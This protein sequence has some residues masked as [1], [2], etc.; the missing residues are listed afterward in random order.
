MKNPLTKMSIAAILLV[1]LIILFSGT[2]QSSIAWGKLLDRLAQMDYTYHHQWIITQEQGEPAVIESVISKSQ[3]YGIRQD[4]LWAGEAFSTV[5]IPRDSNSMIQLLHSNRQV[6]TTVMNPEQMDEIQLK[7]DPSLWIK[8]AMEFQ[9]RL[10]DPQ[11]LDGITVEGIEVTDSNYMAVL[12]EESS[13]HIWVNVETQLP[14][15]IEINGTS[16]QGKLSID[17]IASQFDWEAQLNA[18]V[19]EPNIPADYQH[20]TPMNATDSRQAGIQSLRDYATLTRG[21]YP[22]QLSIMSFM[23]EAVMAIALE[24]FT[25]PNAV[26]PTNAKMPL[27]SKDV[28][29]LAGF[30]HMGVFYGE[31]MADCNDVVY[32]GDHVMAQHSDMI[33][34]R[35]RDKQDSYQVIFGNLEAAQVTFDELAV[36]EQDPE[37]LA[38]LERPRPVMPLVTQGPLIAN[39]QTDWWHIASTEHA[40]VTSDIQLAM[41]NAQAGSIEITLPYPEAIVTEV[42]YLN[43]EYSFE[44]LSPGH[45]RIDL[46]TQDFGWENSHFVCTWTLP[47]A[48]LEHLSKGDYRVKLQGVLPVVNYTL[49]VELG[50]NCGFRNANDLNETLWQAFS[51][52]SMRPQSLMGTCGLGI[53]PVPVSSWQLQ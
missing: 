34:L 28:Q 6:I 4:I 43:R 37:F 46:P 20:S 21:Q 44:A 36:L 8:Q 14:E 30:K 19:F 50:P 31:L 18:Q 11:D 35:W 3:E 53:K 40:E 23:R 39:Q 45:Y 33:L 48:A 47:L 27:T 13:A 51:L 9:H 49:K 2:G 16:E 10:L 42:K 24:R 15:R 17:M 38:I 26:Y 52:N 25:D 7:T 5:Y 12:F 22:A 1:A 32:Y 41:W 29:R